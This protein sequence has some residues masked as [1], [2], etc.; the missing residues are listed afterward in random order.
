MKLKLFAALAAA[1]AF[2]GDIQ[3]YDPPT[4]GWSSW[5]TFG[6]NI[7]ESIINGQADAMV[8][9]GYA[10]CGYV[11]VNIDDGFQ[12]GRD[13][14]TGRLLINK[15]RFPNGLKPVADYIHSKGLK[16]GIYSDAGCNTCGN[17]YNGD[18]LSVDVG[19]YNYD[20]LDCQYYFRECGFDFIKVDFCGGTAYQNRQRM[21][22]DEKERYT[23]IHEAIL[24]T[25]RKDV[26]FN[27]CRWDYPG[28]WVHDISDSWRISQD[29]NCSWRSVKNIIR[30]NLYLSAYCSEGHYNDMD[31]LEVGRTLKAQEDE[32][33]FAIWCIMSSPLLIGCDTRSVPA[34]A[35]VLLQNEELIALNQDPLGLQAY[36]A[37]HDN[38]TYVLVKDVQTL[39]GTRRAVA[40]YNPTDEP[41]D[42][43]IDF[44]KLDLAGNVRVRDLFQHEDL[45]G[46][47][48]GSV[49]VERVPAHGTNVYM[50]HADQRLERTVYEAETGYNSAYQEIRNNQ[51]EKSADYIE[52]DAYS[53]GA[54]VEWL[55]GRAENDLQ[56]RNVYSV[57]GGKYK[58]TMH[59]ASGVDRNVY[60]SVNGGVPV[61]VTCNSGD[62]KKTASFTL[63]VKLNK[64]NN[65]IRFYNAEDWMPNLDK[66]E[67]VSAKAK[68]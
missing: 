11:Y 7:S 58:M 28:T 30:Q 68:K 10:R 2:S 55:G 51:A 20:L 29:I 57:M 46:E 24:R 67:L 1:V 64:G 43:T 21:T 48:R 49:V 19:L 36:V 31:M 41:K 53:N 56:F 61:K 45:K 44:A 62:W 13:Y 8:K 25:G 60:V 18:V 54:G 38:G 12:G 14:E 35:K 39:Y 9:E 23:A 50:L 52:D 6:V 33:H 66:M 32:T 4:M 34:R 15:S 26:K 37:Q 22:L 27:V 63:P 47:A 42:I 40:L 17:Y 3:A 16:A 65:T 5:N 59:Y